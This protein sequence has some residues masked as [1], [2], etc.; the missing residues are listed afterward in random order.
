M[1]ITKKLDRIAEHKARILQ[2]FEE[3]QTGVRKIGDW[4]IR[5]KAGYSLYR[6]SKNGQPP[7]ELD[8]DFT[9]FSIAEKAIREYEAKRQLHAKAE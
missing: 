4:V 2:E 5:R 7:K 8:M 6:V 9:S 3:N 1:T